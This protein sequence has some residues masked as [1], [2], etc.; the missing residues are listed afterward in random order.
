MKRLIRLDEVIRLV[1]LSRSTLWRL[2]RA[3]QFPRRVQLSARAVGWQ[4]DEIELWAQSRARAAY[5]KGELPKIDC[6]ERRPEPPARRA[7][8][9]GA[10][11]SC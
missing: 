9:A 10:R 7:A 3:G 2:E 11:G 4:A 6:L 1:G 5:N 8:K